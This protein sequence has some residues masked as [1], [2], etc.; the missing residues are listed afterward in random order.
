MAAS[1]QS[2]LVTGASAGIGFALVKQ[3]ALEHGCHVYLGS[4]NET[5][6]K[7]CIDSILKANP[8]LKG[9]VELLVLDV[10]LDESVKAAAAKLSGKT[11]YALVNNAGV[12][13]SADTTTILNT[14]LTGVRR[15]CEA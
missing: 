9:R 13:A 6:G 15:M 7:T 3:L 12:G 11:L 10:G 2:V 4:R 1:I 5:K 8:E 14:N